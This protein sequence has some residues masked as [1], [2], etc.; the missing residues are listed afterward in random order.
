VKSR[1][2]VL[3]GV[4]AGL[5]ASAQD[6]PVSDEPDALFRSDVRLVEVSATVF[7]RHG[8]PLP[9]LTQDRFRVLDSGKPQ[10]LVSF[11]GVED[12]VS[13]ALLMDT[14]DSMDAF[15]PVL[16][17]A[18]VRFADELR[19]EEEVGVYTFNSSVQLAQPFTT[20]KRRIKQAVLQARA[21][22]TTALFDAVAS[23]SR[24]LQTRKGKK[25]MVLFTDGA[26]NS[27]MLT[28]LSA[29]R[30]ARL[31]GVPVYAIA[32]GEALTDAKLLDTLKTLA[33]DS[34]GLVFRLDR[35]NQIDDVFATIV[36][37]LR[38][39]YLLAWKLP[40]NAGRAYR[41][42][43]V[44]VTGAPGARIRTRQGYLPN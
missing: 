39:T 28:A 35:P 33:S 16:K 17:N 12:Q 36:G 14:T 29:S 22:G 15:L 7:D 20:D 11:E 24:D 44:N 13:C 32:E 18:V 30:R 37:D 9:G 21:H 5:I 31:S 27:S 1:A 19:D 40:E 38:N 23:V 3:I 26:D 10:Q 43:K 6:R 25:A 42:V 4:L 34:G 8:N 41:T 2:A